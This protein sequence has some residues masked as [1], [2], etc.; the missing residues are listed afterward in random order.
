MLFIGGVWEAFGFGLVVVGVSCGCGIP[1]VEVPGGVA[2]LT[3]GS[4]SGFHFGGG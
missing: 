2:L 3:V 1:E 4:V